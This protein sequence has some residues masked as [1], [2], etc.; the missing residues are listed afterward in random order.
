M[1]PH[2]QICCNPKRKLRF[3]TEQLAICQWCVTE[4]SNAKTSPA[5]IIEE[6]RSSATSKHRDSCANELSHLQRL[7]TP[8]PQIP[9]D[10]LE[11]ISQYAENAVRRDEGIFQSLYRSMFDD[12]KRRDEVAAIAARRGTELQAAHRTAIIDH[13]LRELEIEVKIQT[14]E[15]SILRIPE[16]VELE[17]QRFRNEANTFEPTKFKDLKPVRAF[18]AGLISFDRTEYVELDLPRLHGHI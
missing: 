13:A 4:L 11:Q 5:L 10:A 12:T 14:V 3:H 18:D 17:I 9:N 15:S 1:Q 16:I 2:C 8:P 6:R 7:L